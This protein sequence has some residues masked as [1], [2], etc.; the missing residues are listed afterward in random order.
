MRLLPAVFLLLFTSWHVHAQTYTIST[1]AGGAMP[2]DIP[3][4]CAGLPYQALFSL[5]AD[6]TGN[7]FI[8]YRHTL[9]RL[10]TATGILTVAAGNGT[11]GS[12]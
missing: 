9:L 3:G 10:D 2:V 7:I 12:S 8:S 6:A 1:F 5:A 11:S 4:T